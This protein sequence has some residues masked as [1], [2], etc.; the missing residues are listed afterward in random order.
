LNTQFVTDP[1][2]FAE[3]VGFQITTP[4]TTK[5]LRR[6]IEL[7]VYFGGT[8]IKVT[9]TDVNSGTFAKAALRLVTKNLS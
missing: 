9:A 5:G 4:D 7:S 3:N 2:V 1:G 6:N 8:E